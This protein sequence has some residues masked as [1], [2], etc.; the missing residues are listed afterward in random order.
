MYVL[1]CI[2]V[3][4]HTCVNVQIYIYLYIYIYMYMYTHIYVHIYIYIYLVGLG[5]VESVFYSFPTVGLQTVFL[6]FQLRFFFHFRPVANLLFFFRFQLTFFFVF[7]VSN[8][9]API[10]PGGPFV[11]AFQHF[12]SL[13]HRF[14]FVFS[15][16]PT[17]FS[18][19]FFLL[20]VF[21][22]GSPFFLVF[23]SPF[24]FSFQQPGASNMLNLGNE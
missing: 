19:P 4:I 18:S 10:W 23:R 22:F 8:I 21:D 16:A 2:Y 1:M 5:N 7:N 17:V 6:R 20:Y 9:Q 3:C 24:F 12:T 13:L 11:N 14:F 15:F